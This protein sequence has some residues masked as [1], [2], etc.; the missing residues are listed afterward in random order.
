M[1]RFIENISLHPILLPLKT[2]F[3]TAHG[4]VKNRPTCLLKIDTAHYGHI[5]SECL[6]LNQANYHPETHSNAIKTLDNVLIPFLKKTTLTCASAL[7]KLTQISISKIDIASIEIGLWELMAQ[8]DNQ[9]LAQ[10]LGSSIKE[11][12][13]GIVIG[14]CDTTE[15][16]LNAAKEALMKGYK[17]VK[18]K[19]SPKSLSQLCDCLD[20]VTKTHP[21]T[22]FACDA[23]ESFSK[24]TYKQLKKLI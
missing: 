20:V 6:A 23:N 16:Y 11:V 24:D 5:I 8:Y 3:K 17:K 13:S 14:Q 2:P 19:C 10:F 18:F 12:P 9:T 22:I 4:M 21:S 7:T 1:S 15:D